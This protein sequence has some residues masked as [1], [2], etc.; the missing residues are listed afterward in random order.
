[1]ATSADFIGPLDRASQAWSDEVFEVD[2]I[3]SLS[4]SPDVV[5]HRRE[6]AIASYHGT[7]S[8]LLLSGDFRT[9]KVIAFGAV[10]ES[11]ALAA[12]RAI[13]PSYERD[14][15]WHRFGS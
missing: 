10:A 8:A 13:S 2:C 1:M 14:R 9:A 7:V 15:D 3:A 12:F 5:A 11:R 4:E 6:V